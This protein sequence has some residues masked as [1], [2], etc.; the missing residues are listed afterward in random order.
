MDNPFMLIAIEEAETAASLGEI[1]VGAV[2][3]K[4]GEVIARARNTREEEQ[5]ALYHAEVSAI[6]KACEK[7]G[8]WRLSDCD[9][10]VTLEPCAMCSGA[11]AQAKLRRVYFGAYDKK[12]GFVVSNGQLLDHPALMHKTEYYCGIMEKECQELLKD[13]FSKLRDFEQ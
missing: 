1:P 8:S 6:A 2:I 3:V 11:I 10:Y 7:L 5:N 9:L 13:F 12:G 4:D